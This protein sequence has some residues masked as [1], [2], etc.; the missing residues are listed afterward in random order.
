MITTNL[1]KPLAVGRT[2]EL[3]A[4]EDGRVLKLF[5]NWFDLEHIRFEQQMAQA[6]HASGLPVP[7]PVFFQ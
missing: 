3:F 2:A 5:H 7:E 6:V 4:W 1:G